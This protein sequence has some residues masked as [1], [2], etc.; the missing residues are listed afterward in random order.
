MVKAHK[1]IDEKEFIA[2]RKDLEDFEEKREDLIRKSRD[3]ITQSKEII[4]ALQRGDHAKATSL[5]PAITKAVHSLPDKSYDTGMADV[6]V[7]EYVEAAMFYEVVVE[8][9]LPTR[10][11]LG[12]DTNVYLMGLCDLTGEVLRRAIKAVIEK[13]YSLFKELKALVDEIWGQVLLLELR[14]SE[15]RKKSDQVK[16]AVKRFEEVEYDL[17]MK[18]MIKEFSQAT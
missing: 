7:Q 18:G 10:K 3:I 12:V 15:L 8:K 5:L 11:D 13:D 4:Y 14:N 1:M 9:H 2:I 6:A 16:Y 17:H